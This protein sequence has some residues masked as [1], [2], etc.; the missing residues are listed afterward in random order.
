MRRAVAVSPRPGEAAI[1]CGAT[2]AGL[3]RGGWEVALVTVFDD[4]DRDADHRAAEALGVAEVVH[5]GI[6]RSPIDDEETVAARVAAALGPVLAGLQADR[7]L[8]PLDPER[9]L[10]RIA[11]V[12]GLRWADHPAPVV[13]WRHPLVSTPPLPD[14]RGIPIG[15]LL[16]AKVAACAAY[17][18]TAEVVH[19][20]ALAEG[21][22]LGV[23]GPCEALVEPPMDKRREREARAQAER[24][25][26]A[27]LARIKATIA[28]Y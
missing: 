9:D 7:V 2:L 14:E 25:D 10:D 8:A 1:A 19:E 23:D 16:E 27:A 20:A 22:R 26:R 5:L 28:Q 18:V 15:P 13:R 24:E 17:G 12:N 11:A 21:R 4:G 3:A 6:T